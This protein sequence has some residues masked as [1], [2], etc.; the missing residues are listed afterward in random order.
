M[1]SILLTTTLLLQSALI[2][3]AAPNTP[4]ID[5]T[6]TS[7]VPCIQ[8]QINRDWTGLNEGGD[9]DP[10]AIW[11]ACGAG[12]TSSRLWV[13][14]CIATNY[15]SPTI[16]P[17]K[18]GLTRTQMLQ[19]CYD[20][21][22]IGTH[23]ATPEGACA[24]RGKTAAANSAPCL[25][26]ECTRCPN[27][28]NVKCNPVARQLITYEIPS[29]PPYQPSEVTNPNGTCSILCYLGASHEYMITY[30]VVCHQGCDPTPCSEA[31]ADSTRA[32]GP[33]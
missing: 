14:Q 31:P 26:P 12:R 33:Q 6:D 27:A 22:G 1:K 18:C 20:N 3:S 25:R 29:P 2:C 24:S 11:F 9:Y 4:T 16:G 17:V 8:S 19:K 10:Q 7:V 21:A 28:A 15:P 23:P 5:S 32:G 13:A 30:T